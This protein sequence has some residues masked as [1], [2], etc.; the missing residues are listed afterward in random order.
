MAKKHKHC[1]CYDISTK[2]PFSQNS[3]NYIEKEI[4]WQIKQSKTMKLH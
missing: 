2:I 4:N 3:F 1:Y